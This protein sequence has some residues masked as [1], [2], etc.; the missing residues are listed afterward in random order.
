MR[1]ILFF[2][3][4][5]ISATVMI[6]PSNTLFGAKEI[7]FVAV[8]TI[9][10]PISRLRFS[11]K[12]IWFISFCFLIPCSWSTF[13]GSLAEK[14]SID[15]ALMTI[16]YFFYAL[17]VFPLACLTKEDIYKVFKIAC[18]SLVISYSIVWIYTLL[19]GNSV[20][21]YCGALLRTDV[22]TTRPGDNIPLLGIG[23][24]FYATSSVLLVFYGDL[25]FR[26]KLNPLL[27][28]LVAF[29]ILTSGTQAN[30]FSLLLITCFRLICALFCNLSSQK[31]FLVFLA[32]GLVIF[33]FLFPVLFDKDDGGVSIKSKDA[34]GYFNLW[35]ETP[36]DF[37]V[38]MGLGTSF[39]S[40]GRNEEVFITELMWLEFLRRHGFFITL[41][42]FAYLFYPLKNLLLWPGCKG[43]FIGYLSYLFVA[44][45]NPLL[46]S[47]TGF[48]VITF[49]WAHSIAISGTIGKKIYSQ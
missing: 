32:G 10:L 1:A 5:L 16:K 38:G 15:Y 23:G 39:Y 28:A 34:I 21:D 19:P 49:I 31:Q 35:D 18:S 47:S 48:F 37:F 33:I 6:D 25:I 42:F 44:G 20:I 45:T 36:L 9:F 13:R 3:I 41:A 29:L 14:V 7:L 17:M 12:L 27:I 26:R 24:I 8:W 4:C 40:L 2:L 30:Q 22:F 46:I 43:I 11:K